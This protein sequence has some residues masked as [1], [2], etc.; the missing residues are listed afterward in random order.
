MLFVKR[1]RVRGYTQIEPTESQPE[2]E[3]V[4]VA[5]ASQSQ[6]VARTDDRTSMESV[7][8]H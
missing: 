7:N 3:N 4:F 8:I 1:G 6:P 5:A 2:M